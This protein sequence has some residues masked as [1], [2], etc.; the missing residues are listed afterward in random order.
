MKKEKPA[1]YLAYEKKNPNHKEAINTE[2][3]NKEMQFSQKNI[4]QEFTF[5]PF[6]STNFNSDCYYWQTH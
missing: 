5:N 3:I 6:K 4:K 1:D 2:K